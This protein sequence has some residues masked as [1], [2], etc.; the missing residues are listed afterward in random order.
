MRVGHDRA[1]GNSDQGF[2]GQYTVVGVHFT[3][4][5]ERHRRVSALGIGELN[6]IA[7]VERAAMTSGQ[8]FDCA[9]TSETWLTS[10]P[11]SVCHS[12]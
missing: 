7:P 4:G 12:V 1:L 6:S 2:V 10:R 3:A 11:T 8:R 5:D 9:K